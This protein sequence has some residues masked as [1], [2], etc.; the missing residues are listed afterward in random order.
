MID[1]FTNKTTSRLA[2]DSRLAALQQKIEKINEKIKGLQAQK[3]EIRSEINDVKNLSYRLTTKIKPLDD[4]GVKKQNLNFNKAWTAIQHAM[5][6]S[7]SDGARFS[8]I[9]KYVHRDLPNLNPSTLRSYMHRLKKAKKLKK[10]S[11]GRWV[12]FEAKKT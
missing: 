3:I 8:E 4:R 9:E 2:T 7:G 5:L 11:M 6:D 10:L 1:S 12:P